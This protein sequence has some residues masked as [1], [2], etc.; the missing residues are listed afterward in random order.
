MYKKRKGE[1]TSGQ[2]L[3]IRGAKAREL[4]CRGQRVFVYSVNESNLSWVEG[5]AP[6]LDA[7]PLSGLRPSLQ[8]A[9]DL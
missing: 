1:P 8:D 2:R 7:D 5:L 9:L 6:G 4:V 3:S